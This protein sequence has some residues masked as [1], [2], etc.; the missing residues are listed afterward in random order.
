MVKTAMEYHEEF[1]IKQGFQKGFRIG[2][3]QGLVESSFDVAL[4][5]KNEFGIC[6]ALEISNFSY[7]ELESEEIDES[8]FLI[9][10]EEGV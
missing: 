2:F 6:K 1:L 8:R 9:G 7:D 10:D 4:K 3:N 5:I